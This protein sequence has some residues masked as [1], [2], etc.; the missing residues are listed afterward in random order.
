MNGKVV[1]QRKRSTVS[2]VAD[3]QAIVLE[4]SEMMSRRSLRS[5]RWGEGETTSASSQ[6][7]NLSGPFNGRQ[8]TEYDQLECEK[9]L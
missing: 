4:V 8:R 9:T 5:G 7:R 6:N 3:S 2:R 1:V